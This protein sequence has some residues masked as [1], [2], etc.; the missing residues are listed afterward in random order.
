MNGYLK[1]YE[2]ELLRDGK[3][4]IAVICTIENLDP[5]GIHTGDSIT[6]AP[7]MTLSDTCFQGMRDMAFKMM[8]SM[9]D[10][11]GGWNVQFAVS[12]D[13][14]EDIIAIE[15]NPTGSR[16]SALASKATMIL[17][18]LIIG[19]CVALKILSRSGTTWKR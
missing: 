2:L 17:P 11:A 6:I 7:A 13:E 12:P 18:R 3:D 8:R 15:I 16:S 14:K 9:G 4:D 1:E 10:F 5:M 19:S